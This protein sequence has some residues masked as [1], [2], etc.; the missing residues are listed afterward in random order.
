VAFAGDALVT[1]GT[2]GVLHWPIRKDKSGTT[3]QIGPPRRLGQ[4]TFTLINCSADGRFIAQPIGNGAL[5][6]DRTRPERPILLGPQADVRQVSISA[7]G[8]FAE[9]GS[10]S[11]AGGIRIWETERGKLIKHLP[12]GTVA[13]GTFSPDGRWLA[14]AGGEGSR[15]LTVGTWE[16]GPAIPR[17]K[18]AFSP[19]GSLLAV[20]PFQGAIRLLD[21][22]TGREKVRLE[23]PSQDTTLWLSFTPDGTRLVVV[24]DDGHAIHVWDLKRIRE[25]LVRL[26]L[27]WE[28]PPYPERASTA[29]KSLTIRVIGTEQPAKL[30]EAGEL[31][32][33]AWPLVAGP[34]ARRKPAQALELIQ[35]AVKLTPD[36]AVL[37]NTLGVAQYRNGQY[38][39]A[40][41][42]LEKSLAAGRGESDAYDLFF[43]AMCHARLGK[44]AKAK[45]CFDRAVKWVEARK[46][47]RAQEVEELRAF[48]AEAEVALRGLEEPGR[49]GTRVR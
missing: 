14:V 27:D 3:W 39:A 23:D 19:D 2:A 17:G 30:Q 45:D 47:A 15:V 16:E 49:K 11:V 13:G 24:A 41:V 33:Q 42:T 48:R 37:L 46:N 35:K 6:L 10:H 4:G 34:P 1:N 43:L 20:D 32:N 44:P 7:D 38:A 36:N 25:E 31:N 29:P 28:A 8:R 5:V 26:G 22:A 18:M 21:P 9:T 12:L 40:L